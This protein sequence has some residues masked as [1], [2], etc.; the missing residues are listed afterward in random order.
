MKPTT[1]PLSLP[2][3]TRSGPCS[4]LEPGAI[5]TCLESALRN[6]G[7]E[8]SL[9]ATHPHLFSAHTVFVTPADLAAMR[10][11]IRAIEQVVAHPAYAAEAL[12]HAPAGARHEPGNPGAFLGFDFHL[13]PGGPKL[14]EINT[15]AGGMLLG[16]ALLRAQLSCC[17]PLRAR[18]PGHGDPDRIEADIV[19]MLRH[20]WH[21]AGR[22]TP[23][24]RIVIVDENPSGQFLYP[25]FVLFEKLFRRHGIEAAIAA[26]AELAVRDRRL[27]AG[28]QPVDLVYN[29]LTD[30]ALAEPA[31]AVLRDAW[32]AN[33]AVVT[34]HPRAYALYAD[35]RNLA[36]LSDRDWLAA[37]GVAPA[38]RD[39]LVGGIAATR[40]LDPAHADTLWAARKR[41]FFKPA[42]GYGSKAVYRGDKLTRRVW[43]EILAGEYV[44][45]EL[46]PPA[47]QPADEARQ[48][49]ML[50][51]DVRHF[52]YRGETQ[53]LTA[54]LYQGQTTNFRT[55]GGGF[56]PVFL[57][58]PGESP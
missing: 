47:E 52:V 22:A 35:K 48:P 6:A 56:A 23:L 9:A 20:E 51:S 30:F 53:L 12:R 49:A 38:T 58:P 14:I 25:E 15:N 33:L 37:L 5:A 2:A 45:Q 17:A 7:L 1:A 43:E 29:R 42:T 16:A 55:P 26:P 50:K 27:W 41:L 11:V 4:H 39:V 18:L 21:A 10:A 34:P 44:A 31:H 40:R 13:D 54:R 36:L 19:D 3:V 24:A 28:S 46:V 32:L 57:A 8:Q